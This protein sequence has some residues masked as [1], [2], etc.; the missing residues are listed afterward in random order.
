MASVRVRRRSRA[1][2]LAYVPVEPNRVVVVPTDNIPQPEQPNSPENEEFL[3]KE[4]EKISSPVAS[5]P[6]TT[7]PGSSSPLR[8]TFSRPTPFGTAT[9]PTTSRMRSSTVVEPRSPPF[10][11]DFPTRGAA[12]VFQ[13]SSDSLG[14]DG[15]GGLREANRDSFMMSPRDRRGSRSSWFVDHVRGTV[16]KAAAGAAAALK[17]EGDHPDLARS[18]SP[19]QLS[20]ASSVPNVD[21]VIPPDVR[22]GISAILAKRQGTRKDPALTDDEMHHNDIVEHLDVIA[23]YSRKPVV[24][25]PAPT[26]LRERDAESMESENELDAHVEEA[27]LQASHSFFELIIVAY[28]MVTAIYGFLVVFWGAAIVFFLGKLINLHDPYLQGFWVEISSQVVNGLF[29]V[30]GV[31]FL[32]WRIMD[33]WNTFW[34]Y[35]Y[36]CKDRTLRRRANLPPVGDFNDIPDPYIESEHVQMLTDKQLQ[37][38]RRH[39]HRAFSLKYVYFTRHFVQLLILIRVAIAICISVDMNSVFQVSGPSNHISNFQHSIDSTLWMHVGIESFPET[40]MDSGN[41]DSPQFPLRYRIRYSHL[42]RRRAVQKDGRSQRTTTTS[43]PT[44]EK[45][46]EPTLLKAPPSGDP[47]KDMNGRGSSESARKR[48]PLLKTLAIDETMTIPEDVEPT[49]TSSNKETRPFKEEKDDSK[50]V[51]VTPKSPSVK[52]FGDGK[53]E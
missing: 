52:D 34:I 5:S 15:Q 7:V 21:V 28:Y 38:L 53:A 20:A 37:W 9:R 18:I 25:L 27:S 49:T 43:P 30:Q 50:F 41:L 42:E 33:S 24:S 48:S 36:A 32:P 4:A 26:R 10:I 17:P 46:E 29:T 6:S 51:L 39:T 45:A 47:E 16:S 31:G 44:R 12:S 19:D 13:R 22:D 2:P 23:W 1:A 14:D 11:T 40:A 8:T 35:H 3:R